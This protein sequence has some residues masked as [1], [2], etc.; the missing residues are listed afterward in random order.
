MLKCPGNF[1]Y[2]ICQVMAHLSKDISLAGGNTILNNLKGTT[3][4]KLKPSPFHIN[5]SESVDL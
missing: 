3:S 4:Y 1:I 5:P 2:S